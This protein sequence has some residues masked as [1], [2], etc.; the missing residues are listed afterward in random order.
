M[1]AWATSTFA[2]LNNRQFR[3]LWLGSALAFVAFF[4]STV[5]QAVVAF[6]LSG[7]N[8]A[9]GFVVFAQGIAQLFLGPLGGALADRLS[10]KLV[11]LVCQLTIMVSFFVIGLL[12]ATDIITVIYLATGSFIIGVAFSFLGPSR[13]AFM[14]EL[15]DASRRGN[16]VALSQVALNASRILAPLIAGAMLNIGFLGAEGAFIGMGVLYIG[17]IMTTIALPNSRVPDVQANRRSI[18]GDIA[19]GI[20]YVK[21]HAQLRLLVPS[22]I[23][24]IMFGFSYVSVLPGFLENELGRDP[25]QITL[26]LGV[27]AIGGLGA[28]L[29]VAALA[30]SR[31]ARLIYSTM[32]LVFGIAVVGM[33]LSPNYAALAAVMFV[34]G[35]GGG[36]FQTLNGAIVS[37]LT[38][39]DYFGRV[40]SLTFL[41]FASSSMVALPVGYLADAIGERHTLLITGSIVCAVTV[42][43]WLM[44]RGVAAGSPHA[45]KVTST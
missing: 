30:D 29:G 43:F 10:K 40:V 7:N 20:T 42:I 31:H 24:V 3:T 2:A 23:L 18:L 12:V 38:D 8:G 15:V 34:A 14:M 32:C 39:P 37:H 27:N 44:G 11:I 6:D 25:K 35:F 21:G 4:M 19:T 33:A 17:A 22:Y 41:A 28:S 26:L 36:G 1:S 5:V 13:Q 45:A 9:V 16:A